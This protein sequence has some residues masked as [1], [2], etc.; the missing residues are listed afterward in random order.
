MQL[1]LHLLHARGR[2]A[3]A[4]A[5]RGDDVR[6]DRAARPDLRAALRRPRDPPHRW[7]T[8]R[9][10]APSRAG[11]EARSDR[12][13]GRSGRSGDDHQRRHDATRRP[14]AARRRTAAGQHQPRHA[15]PGEVPADDPSRRTRAGARRHRGRQ[16]GRVLAGQDQRGHR[17]G[18]ERRRDRRAGRVRPQTTTSRFASSSSCRSTPTGTG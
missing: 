1:P 9:A 11:R 8:D 2:D 3:V 17:A 7:R 10:G 16:G 14:D 6:R 5:L 4:P 12:G 18:R 13:T 15:R